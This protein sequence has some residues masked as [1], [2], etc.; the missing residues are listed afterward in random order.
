MLLA[1]KPFSATHTRQHASLSR[2][3]MVSTS[4]LD[5]IVL[6]QRQFPIVEVEKFLDCLLAHCGSVALDLIEGYNAVVPLLFSKITSIA[7]D[8]GAFA[9]M[10]FYLEAI[11]DSFYMFFSY[12]S[13]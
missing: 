10:S 9:T 3:L 5:I 13:S 11:K 7:P 2:G 6:I 12:P 4:N 8:A 1:S